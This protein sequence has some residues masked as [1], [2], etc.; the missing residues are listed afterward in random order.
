MHTNV[1]AKRVHFEPLSIVIDVFLQNTR[2]LHAGCKIIVEYDQP[3]ITG[4]VPAAISG[5]AI[6]GALRSTN[7]AESLQ[8]AYLGARTA[9]PEAMLASFRQRSSV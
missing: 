7:L 3:R 1:I 2:I 9:I 6:I 4:F 5:L 8:I